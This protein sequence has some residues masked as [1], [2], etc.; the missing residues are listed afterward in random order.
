VQN[1][2]YRVTC[3]L[4]LQLRFVL[5]D[6]NISVTVKFFSNTFTVLLVLFYIYYIQIKLLLLSYITV[7]SLSIEVTNAIFSCLL[8]YRVFLFLNMF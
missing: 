1:L 2:G 6:Q 4:K 7:I 8:S 5:W 3:S